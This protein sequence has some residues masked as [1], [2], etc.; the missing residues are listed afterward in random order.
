MVKSGA[1]VVNSV[2]PLI[3]HHSSGTETTEGLKDVVLMIKTPYGGRI[4]TAYDELERV[5]QKREEEKK[6]I[7][8][9]LDNE[10]CSRIEELAKLGIK[11]V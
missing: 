2:Y 10:P 8:A 6:E 9:I 4:T 11:R 5:K 1:Y 7:Q 3:N